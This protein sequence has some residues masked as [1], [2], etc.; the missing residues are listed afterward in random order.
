MLV[1]CSDRDA[2]R[3]SSGTEAPG[4][5]SHLPPGLLGLLLAGEAGLA[6]RVPTVAAVTMS[7]GRDPIPA[8][9]QEHILPDTGGP[10]CAAVGSCLSHSCNL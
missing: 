1:P 8:T 9:V 10:N 6:L 5:E 3:R 2:S 4:V 7:G